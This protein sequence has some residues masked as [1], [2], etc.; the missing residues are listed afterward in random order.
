VQAILR[1]LFDSIRERIA[2]TGLQPDDCRLSI[3]MAKLAEWGDRPI[4]VEALAA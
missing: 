4:D 2:S 1:Q 3:T